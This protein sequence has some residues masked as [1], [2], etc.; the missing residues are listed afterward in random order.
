MKG[1]PMLRLI[2]LVAGLAIGLPGLAQTT[3]APSVAQEQELEIRLWRV[4]RLGDLMPIMRDE[5][6]AEAEVMRESLFERGGD[7]R[8]L[9]IVA[10]IHE[11]GRLERLLRRGLQEAMAT[12]PPA[13]IEEALAFY[14]T[15]LGQRL[16]GLE[17]SARQVMLDSDAE[18]LAKTRF[19]KAASHGIPRVEQIGRLIEKADLVGPNVAGGM[20]AALAFSRGFDEGG[21]YLAPMT[22]AQMLSDAWAQEPLI[23][24]ETLGWMEAYLFLAYS[25]LNDAELERYTTF[26][27]SPAG[28]TLA[29]VLF[30]GFDRLLAQTSRD[31]GLAAAGQI[32]GRKL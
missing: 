3:E 19:A 18:A 22:E 26:S 10:R 6:L 11:T 13:L 21:G 23:R 5:A 17:T 20:N 9:D 31:M 4:L 12:E 8:W 25:P 24:A 14:E 7:D 32:E 29:H 1:A 15:S 28:R 30:A 16:I 27:A 2:C